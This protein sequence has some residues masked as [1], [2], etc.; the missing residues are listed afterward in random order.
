MIQPGPVVSVDWLAGH[1]N[2]VRVVDIRWYLAELEQGRREYDQ[3]HLPGAVFVDLE[4]DVSGELGRGRHPLPTAERFAVAMGRIGVDNATDV[5]VYDQNIGAI[6]SRLWW[7]LRH[8][9]HDRVSVLDGGYSAWVGAGLPVTRD[10]FQPE[11]ALFVPSEQDGDMVVRE[12]LVQQ[13]GQV[14]LIDARAPERY[15]GDTEP[16]DP[17]AGHIPTAINIPFAQAARDGRFAAR[18]ELVSI[19]GDTD[20]AVVYCGSGVTACHTVLAA[21]HA[22]LALP[23]LYE[24]S[25]SDW[26]SVDLPIAVGP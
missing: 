2:S 14:R 16:I 10:S 8:F 23:L 12:D 25:W 11:P 7:L 18:D 1:L 3:G 15:R 19:L 26:A 22:S 4:N 20:G 6:A 17:K 5:V 21:A 9:G 24:G 13:L